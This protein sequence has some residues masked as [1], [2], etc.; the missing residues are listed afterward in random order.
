MIINNNKPYIHP[1]FPRSLYEN[2]KS[3]IMGPK[4]ASS[5]YCFPKELVSQEAIKLARLSK[6]SEGIWQTLRTLIKEAKSK[7]G[8]SSDKVVL[9]FGEAHTVGY[10]SVRRWFIDNLP[11][12][13]EELGDFVLAFEHPEEYNEVIAEG[14]GFSHKAYSEKVKETEIEALKAVV[15]KFGE[16][17]LDPRTALNIV[18]EGK[19]FVQSFSVGDQE[20]KK[21]MGSL[22]DFL[23][24]MLKASN[25]LG[26]NLKTVDLGGV[27]RS[28]WVFSLDAMYGLMK[29][30]S[31]AV[32]NG[33]EEAAKEFSEILL[34]F[35]TSLS[36][37][38]VLRD[39]NISNKI[40]EI[41]SKEDKNVV[42]FGGSK[43][44][45][46]NKDKSLFPS[47][48][49]LLDAKGI[50]L[51]SLQIENPE[52]MIQDP[53]ADIDEEIPKVFEQAI[54]FIRKTPELSEN[55]KYKKGWNFLEY[56]SASINSYISSLLEADKLVEPI[57]IR[58]DASPDIA[59]RETLIGTK[60]PLFGVAH[61]AVLISSPDPSS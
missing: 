15:R 52:Y 30:I 36:K 31:L 48:G 20:D 39:R 28:K 22:D 2:F 8:I 19:E 21:I 43:H 13:K 3:N 17:G 32:D 46:R 35:T 12:L 56:F 47:A 44:L 37:L 16:F 33:N 57:I 42:Y 51:V 6:R 59:N 45:S 9:N 10:N 38:S 54:A 18:K 25:D 53:E 23:E 7:K 5:Q 27:S 4:E 60:G 1:G 61:D 58:T 14:G 40:R 24:D 41:I 49:D 26:L 29:M 55:W 11:R 34:S 50:P